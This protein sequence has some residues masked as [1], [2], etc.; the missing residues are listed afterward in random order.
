MFDPAKGLTAKQIQAVLRGLGIAFRDFDYS[1]ATPE[2]R[3]R[4]PYQKFVYSGIESGVGALVGF[5]FSGP[6]IKDEVRHIIPFYGHTFNKDTWAP[7]AERSYFRVGERLGY[8][9]SEYWTSSFLGHDDNLGPNFCV[10]RLYMSPKQVVYAVE[11]LRSGMAF[12]GAQA[13]VLSLQFLYSVLRQIDTGTNEW[14]QR[15]AH[16][17]G[18]DVQRIVLRA[19]AV[20]RQLY[21]GHLSGERDWERHR[22]GHRIVGVLQHFLPEHL[23]VVEVSVPELFPA[24]ERKLGDIVLDG[25]IKISSDKKD[26]SNFVMA[27]LP[28]VYLFDLSE[29]NKKPSFLSFPSRL[30]SHV[31]VIRLA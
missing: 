24:N 11:L 31:P 19:I 10:P 3:K 15:L 20:D 7:E 30:V 28:S 23:W 12:G 13:E 14:L 25:G 9:P 29:P 16:Y 2:E 5:R 27:R 26:R 6:A 8:V 21:V 4:Y 18:R 22:E 1:Q 17:A